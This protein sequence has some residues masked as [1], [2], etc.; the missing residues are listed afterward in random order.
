MTEVLAGG[1]AG[2]T[3][4]GSWCLPGSFA[5]H[6]ITAA[7]VNSGVPYV[8]KNPLSRAFL[9]CHTTS[10]FSVTYERSFTIYW[11]PAYISTH[12]REYSHVLVHSW[13]TCAP[14]KPIQKR[15]CTLHGG[16]GQLERIS[17]FFVQYNQCVPT[18]DY[19]ISCAMCNTLH[20]SGLVPLALY[21][22]HSQL[23]L[24]TGSANV[25]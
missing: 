14:A 12:T 18:C 15:A 5:P 6:P 8:A 9:I 1:G 23:S 3:R 11:K 2:A 17:R 24:E 7:L 4:A 19:R 16:H 20:G 22:L 10:H 25:D 21:G 13:K